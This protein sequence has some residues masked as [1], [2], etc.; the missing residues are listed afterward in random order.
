MIDFDQKQFVRM[1]YNVTA[2]THWNFLSDKNNMI[3]L[4]GDMLLKLKECEDDNTFTTFR[5]VFLRKKDLW[6]LITK[7]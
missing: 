7:N 2:G 4:S 5:N 1:I 3:K 6:N